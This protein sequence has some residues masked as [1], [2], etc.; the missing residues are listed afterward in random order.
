MITQNKFT[1]CDEIICSNVEGC[2]LSDDVTTEST[3]NQNTTVF[4][5]KCFK[6]STHPSTPHNFYL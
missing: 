6:F 1:M 5:V 3:Y 4:R 2:Y